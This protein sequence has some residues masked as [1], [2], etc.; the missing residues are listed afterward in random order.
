MATKHI[1]SVGN[2]SKSYFENAA[3]QFVWPINFN[4]RTILVPENELELAEDDLMVKHFRTHGWHIQ[5]AIGE[6]QKTKV[7]VAPVSDKL[8]F[9]PTKTDIIEVENKFKIGQKFKVVSTFCQLKIVDMTKKSITLKYTNRD[10]QDLVTTEENLSKA[11]R[12]GNFVEV[13]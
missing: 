3:K 11:I 7:Y 10:K 2:P 4:D 13:V 9:K 12:L 8:I 1:K 6:V 5:S